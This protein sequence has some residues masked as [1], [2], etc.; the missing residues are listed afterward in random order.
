MVYLPAQWI[1][2]CRFAHVCVCL[3]AFLLKCSRYGVVGFG[4]GV[5]WGDWYRYL[6]ARLAGAFRG[7]EPTTAAGARV[8]LSVALEQFVGCPVVYGFYLIPALAVGA[9]LPKVPWLALT[10]TW[11]SDLVSA[12][13]IGTFYLS[14]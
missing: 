9:V 12:F 13:A 7:Q 6:D 5:L 3:F 4:S 10:L 1:D 14:F 2:S 8:A 11:L